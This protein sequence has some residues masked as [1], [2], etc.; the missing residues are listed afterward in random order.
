LLPADPE[1]LGQYHVIV[2][3]NGDP[4]QHLPEVPFHTVLLQWKIAD[5]AESGDVPERLREIS[6]QL[7]AE[8]RELMVTMRGE[9][10]S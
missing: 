3:L 7:S 5:A 1:L 10:A 6:Q 4:G 9:E 2:S 8:I